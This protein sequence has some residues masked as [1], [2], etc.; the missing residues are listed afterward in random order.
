MKRHPHEF[1]GLKIIPLQNKIDGRGHFLK[2]YQHSW[3]GPEADL[4]RESFYSSSGAGVIRGM[5]FQLPPKH[6]DKLV[7]CMAGAATDVILDLRKD[8]QTFGDHCSFALNGDDPTAL[9][10]PKGF[11]HGFQ[12]LKDQTLIV[13]FVG[14]EY[15]PQADCGVRWDSFG[16]AWSMQA[17]TISERDQEFAPLADFKSPF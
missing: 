10:I 4:F 11:A 17:T 3:L 8:S 15:D 16:M 14:S 1:A 13:Y 2:F 7:V 9:F 5:H 12:A 6:H